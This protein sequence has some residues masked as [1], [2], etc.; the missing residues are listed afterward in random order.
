MCK[1]CGK[2]LILGIDGVCPICKMP[3]CYDCWAK[4]HR[5]IHD[6]LSQPNE[7]QNRI[8][9]QIELIKQGGYQ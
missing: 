8:N 5:D 1:E 7:C 9:K 6:D 3:L 2:E 4:K